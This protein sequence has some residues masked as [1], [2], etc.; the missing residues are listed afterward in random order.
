[1]SSKIAKSMRWHHDQQ[2]DDGLLRHLANSLAWKSFDSKFPSF[3][4]NPQNVRLGLAADGFNP[5]KIRSTSYSTWPVVLVPYNLPPWICM[6]QSSFILSMIIPGDKSLRNEFDIYMQPLI[7]ELKQLWWLDRNH[8]FRFQKT[9][10][11]GTEE[12][13]EA[14][15]Q[16]IEFEIL[17]MLKDIN[18]SYGKMNQPPN[19]QTKRRSRDEYDDESDE[20]DDSNEE[21]DEEDDPNEADLWKKKENIIGIILNVDGKS[22]DNLQSQLDLVDMGIRRD[23]HP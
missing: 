7:E 5:F 20:E 11:D 10:F 23:L 13:R 22:K 14:P 19:T 15:E 2:T 9:L 12:F 16:T 1:M 17:F 3:A 4:S 6:K 21:S 18:F 8:R